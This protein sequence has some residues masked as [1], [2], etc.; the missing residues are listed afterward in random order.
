MRLSEL[1]PEL[2]GNEEVRENRKA[3]LELAHRL[4]FDNV[5]RTIARSDGGRVAVFGNFSYRAVGALCQ[6]IAADGQQF[7]AS[8]NG[9]SV[10][11]LFRFQPR[12]WVDEAVAEAARLREAGEPHEQYVDRMAQAELAKWGGAPLDTPTAGAPTADAEEVAEDETD[13][14]EDPTEL[15]TEAETAEEPAVS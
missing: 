4:D 8:R 3:A 5:V 1:P 10:L 6:V 7:Y 12:E 9:G 2:E 11:T 15:D 14:A 13:E